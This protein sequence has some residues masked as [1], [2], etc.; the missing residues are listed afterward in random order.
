M[1]DTVTIFRNWIEIADALNSDEERGKFYHAICKYSIY[2]EVP[3]L[4]G[5][6]GS[7]FMLMQPTIDKSNARKFAQKKSLQIRL[8]RKNTNNMQ[9]N[10]QKNLQNGLQND[11]QK[12]LQKKDKKTS[13]VDRLPEHLRTASFQL[14][15]AEWENFRRKKRKP[16]SETAANMQFKLLEAFDEATA[17][18]IID[19]S[20]S[21]D[22]QGLF[23]PKNRP[24][25]LQEKD[26]S[27]I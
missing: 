13:F 21:N 26:Y 24:T 2:G 10:V 15:W 20:I 4:D 27:G 1:I 25:K 12:N 23:P 22:Y 5:L 19:F 9:N 3:K 7:F 16:I 17:S 8:Q 6:L 11:V 14:K 18:S